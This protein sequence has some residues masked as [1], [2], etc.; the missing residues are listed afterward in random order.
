MRVWDRIWDTIM[1]SP[2][3]ASLLRTLEEA[4]PKDQTVA[5]HPS[6][7]PSHILGAAPGDLMAERAEGTRPGLKHQGPIK[8]ADADRSLNRR[9]SGPWTGADH[10]PESP[11]SG[12]ARRP[13]SPDPA[14][15]PTRSAPR[16]RVDGFLN[17]A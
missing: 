3:S 7:G 14:R 5:S 4:I 6:P 16:V 1:S 11:E 2:R 9:L 15:P 8:D 10:A 13:V 17:T 12:R